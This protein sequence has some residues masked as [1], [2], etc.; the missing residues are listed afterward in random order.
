VKW[1]REAISDETGQAD[2]AY[3]AI[4]LLTLSATLSLGFVS[5]MQAISYF[6]CVP[7]VKA[8]VVVNCAFDPL[9]MG[10]AAGL[11]FAA[12]ASLIASLSGY[13]LATR[14]QRPQV[15]QAPVTSTVTTTATTIQPAPAEAA[16]DVDAT[17]LP[18]KPM[19]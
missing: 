3:A 17:V 10:Q 2:I 8:D 16:T 15:T 7:L 1:L 6:R 9:P 14:K 12:F 18:S 11:I 5:L 19:G 13:M 4:A